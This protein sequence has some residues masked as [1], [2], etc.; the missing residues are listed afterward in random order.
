[1]E[2]IF[3]FHSL[4]L[5][6]SPYGLRSHDILYSF[7][8]KTKKK[9]TVI[10]PLNISQKKELEFYFR[11]FK[12]R[13]LIL[14]IKELNHKKNLVASRIISILFFTTKIIKIFYKENLLKKETNIYLTNY[15]LPLTLFITILSFFYR[16]KYFLDVRDLFVDGFITNLVIKSKKSKNSIFYFLI[17]FFISPFLIFSET[18]TLFFAKKIMVTSTGY[19]KPIKI[20]TFFIKKPLYL[21]IG[22]SGINK[23]LNKSKINTIENNTGFNKATFAYCGFLDNVFDANSIDIFAKFLGNNKKR[24]EGLSIKLFGN[25]K[26]HYSLSKKYSFVS[27]SYISKKSMLI[28]MN[29]FSW[30][31]YPSSSYYPFN[32]ILGNKIFDYIQSGIPIISIGARCNASEFIEKNLI[33]FHIDIKKESE[34]NFIKIFK[35]EI[36]N[37]ERYKINILK[38]SNSKEFIR[39]Y[40][41]L[42]ILLENKN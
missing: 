24:F 12:N 20:R 7:L 23:K 4:T 39:N 18:L 1:M 35:N 14:P 29:N 26:A 38:I 32:T 2:V 28:E 40:E 30:G 9:C 11:K 37:Y 42:A 36:K 22:I 5:P 10:A 33:G 17:I 25:S 31:I 15:S 13:I 3:I 21:P 34:K 41:K 27:N 6:S 16:Y 8:K 19:I